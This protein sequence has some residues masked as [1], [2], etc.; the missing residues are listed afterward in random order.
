MPFEKDP[1]I[2]EI[3]FSFPNLLALII[4]LSCIIYLFWVSFAFTKAEAKENTTVIQI[5]SAITVLLTT[6]VQYYF[7]NSNNSKAQAAQITELQKTATQVA[8]NTSNANIA[9][10]AMPNGKLAEA[11][12]DALI[13]LQKELD[14]LDPESEEAKKIVAELEAL[15]KIS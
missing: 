13:R 5:I 3:K 14:A 9:S 15:E 2:G 10:A 1:I 4:A 7:G 6:V 11:R 12:E 8:L